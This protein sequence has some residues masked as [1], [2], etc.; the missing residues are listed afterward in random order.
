LIYFDLIAGAYAIKYGS[1]L[2]DA[3]FEADLNLALAIIF[4]PTG[5]NIAKWLSRSTKSNSSF[6]DRDFDRDYL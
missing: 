1:L 3:P 5:L 4:V 2:L 6:L